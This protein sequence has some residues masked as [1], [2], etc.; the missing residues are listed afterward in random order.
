M[1]RFI[2]VLLFTLVC[3]GVHAA[4]IIGNE[5]ALCDNGYSADGSTCTSYSTTDCDA[6][7]HD[8]TPSNASFLAPTNNLCTYSG[9]SA[10]TLPD[11]TITMAYHG[12]ILGD[13]VVLCNNGYSS[14]NSTCTTYSAGD[15]PTGYLAV[16]N[17][18]ASFAVYNGSCA[19]GYSK[20]VAEDSCGFELTDSTCV[21]FCPSNLL[22]TGAGTCSTLCDEGATVIRTSTGLRYPLWATKGTTPSLN[23]G[24]DN[25][26][27]CY[28]NLTSE[29]T[30]E[31]SI[32][33]QWEN[34][35]MHATK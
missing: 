16:S 33:V 25:G 10:R 19:T 12:F 5:I 13:E 20:Y 31:T 24:F 30:N 17:S 14:D 29:P 15:C 21:S 6:G 28:V 26:N 34:S 3:G 23:I 32:W 18:E 4:Q 9:Y 8:L 2:F 22:T 11:T 7:Y 35:K 27:R 1:K